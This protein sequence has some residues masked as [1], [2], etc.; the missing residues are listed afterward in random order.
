MKKTFIV[1]MLSI[2]ILSKLCAQTK[3]PEDKTFQVPENVIMHSRFYIDLGNKNRFTI[4]LSDISDLQKI[5]NIDSLLTVF[6]NDLKPLKDSLSDPLTS[7]RIDYLTD[8]QNRKKIRIQQY[9]PKGDNYLL[10]NGELSSLKINQDTI[11]ILGVIVNPSTKTM[12]KKVSSTAPR[13]YHLIFYLNNID[14]LPNYMNGTL[15]EK[16]VS[17]QN[18]VNGKWPLKKG[19][20]SHYME[21]DK[22]IVADKPRG[23]TQPGGDFIELSFSVLAQNYKSY[24]VP[25]FSLGVDFGFTNPE[26]T[27]KWNP[28]IFWEPH[29]FFSKDAQ[30]KLRTYRNDFLTVTYGQGGTTDRDPHKDFSFSALFSLGYA[31]HRSGDFVQENTFRIG[32][33]KL[34]LLKTTI[35]PALYFD[36]FFKGVT[37]SIRITQRF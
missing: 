7:K 34:K 25:A 31:I 10:N 35:E 18:N 29:F 28:G 13:Y 17:I 6:L 3:T 22:T 19:G 26:R 9:H 33:G 15:T 37:P 14:E 24:F 11:N 20:S 36:H 27:F 4:E 21:N 5:A 1:L 23:E 8:E 2:S 30:G 32:A 16:I 12:A